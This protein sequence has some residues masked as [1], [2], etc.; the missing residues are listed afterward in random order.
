MPRDFLRILW[1]GTGIEETGTT[2]D[3]ANDNSVNRHQIRALE[4]VLY[5][6]DVHIK[7]FW[8][9]DK[10]NGHG[11]AFRSNENENLYEDNNH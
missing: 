8:C 7:S 11:V 9:N 2:A 6:V 3:T 4:F 10:Y 5:D 1:R